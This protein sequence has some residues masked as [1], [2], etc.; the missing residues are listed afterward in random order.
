MVSIEPADVLAPNSA[1]PLAG[2]IQLFTTFLWLFIFS[3]IIATTRCHFSREVTHCGL[4]MPYDDRSGWIM[5]PDSNSELEN[6]LVKLFPHNKEFTHWGS[7]MHLYANKLAHHQ[8]LVYCLF[9]AKPL[10]ESMPTNLTLVS[11]CHLNFNLKINSFP[12]KINDK[13]CQQSGHGIQA[14]MC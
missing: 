9:S 5:L 12:I 1:R 8:A 3:D 14:S 10:P 13:C 6:I 4:V 2:T 7:V 11:K